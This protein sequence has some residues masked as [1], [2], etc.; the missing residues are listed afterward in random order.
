M[1]RRRRPV[2]EIAFSFDSFL[3]LVANVVG[4]IIRLILVVWVSAKAY[5]PPPEPA[6]VQA[7]APATADDEAEPIPPNLAA[8][9]EALAR[10]E[11]ELLEQLQTLRATETALD[12]DRHGLE[13]T[14]GQRKSLEAERQDLDRAEARDSAQAVAAAL[15]IEAAQRRFAGIMEQIALVRKLPPARKALRYRTP[16]S[17]PV[18]ADE[19]LFEVQAGRVTFVDIH[20][21]LE[22]VKHTLPDK[23]EWL[24]DHWTVQDVT[25][26]V[27]AFQLS[28][29]VERDRGAF[30]GLAAG[31]PDRQANFRYGVAAWRVEPIAHRRGEDGA[32]ALAPGS[33]FRHVVESL[34]GTQ[35]VVTFWV[36]PDSFELYRRLRDYLYEHDLIV[37]GR[38]LPVGVPISSS[39]NGSASRGQ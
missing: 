11:A 37:A 20:A 2:R 17:A 9:R 21:L 29:Q 35:A 39:R 36:Y 34:D 23:V 33:D 12:R 26:P 31:P 14:A 4:I 8:D 13:A 18:D 1:I 28:Y 3:D 25:G 30:E 19:V 22:E 27:G 7:L 15:S 38:P 5:V 6:M 24:R 10:V 16:V 32:A